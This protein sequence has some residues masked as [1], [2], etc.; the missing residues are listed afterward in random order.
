MITE[1]Q[2]VKRR[3]TCIEGH[4]GGVRR[5]IEDDIRCMDILQQTYAIR[6]AIEQVETRLVKCHL[7]TCVPQGL[8]DGKIDQVMTELVSLYDL[9]GNR[10]LGNHPISGKGEKQHDPENGDTQAASAAFAATQ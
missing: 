9:V 1:K 7:Q 8:A 6:K 4:L 2:E 3:L 10:L 5:M